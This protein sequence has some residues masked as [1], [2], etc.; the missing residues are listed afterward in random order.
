MHPTLLACAAT[1]MYG[2]STSM[3]Y[4]LMVTC[5]SA[6]FGQ[7]WP[8]KCMQTW[9][10]AWT[11]TWSHRDCCQHW[12]KCSSLGTCPSVRK[13]LLIAWSCCSMQH[14]ILALLMS[15]AP[16]PLSLLLQDDRCSRQPCQFPRSECKRLRQLEAL[17][18]HAQSPCPH[19]QAWQSLCKGSSA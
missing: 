4:C 6:C 7:Q 12:C 17:P 10:E 3:T 16:A 19:A 11:W 5:Q 15:R 14:D 13:R 1:W 9:R 18:R 8:L 2:H